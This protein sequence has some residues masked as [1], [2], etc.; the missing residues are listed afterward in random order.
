MKMKSGILSLGLA[1]LAVVLP[2]GANTHSST[3]TATS[4]PHGYKTITT[5]EL[6]KVIDGNTGV[7]IF[8]ARKKYKGGFISGAK[9]LPY[10]SSEK[11]ISDTLKS[12]PKNAMIVVYCAN[13]DCPVSKYLAE[14]LVGMGYTNVYKYPDGIAGWLDAEY[15]TNPAN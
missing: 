9:G 10:D 4:A 7:L 2:C 3:E 8:D 11:E 14:K 5:E 1:L 6:K 12:T 15:P 13:P